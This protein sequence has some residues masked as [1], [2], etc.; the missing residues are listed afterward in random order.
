MVENET[1]SATRACRMI[2]RSSQLLVCRGHP[3]PGH[4]VTDISLFH[5]TQ[6]IYTIKSCRSCKANKFSSDD[7]QE[8]LGSHYQELTIEELIEMHEQEQELQDPVQSE[9]RMTGWKFD[10][11]P[12]F[13]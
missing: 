7:V 1:V 10:K 13:N 12:R 2:L 6:H 4:R 5:R 11:K 8:L 9:D 3:E